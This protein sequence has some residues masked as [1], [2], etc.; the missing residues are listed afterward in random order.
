MSNPD[1][2]TTEHNL[3]QSTHLLNF[4]VVGIGASAGGLEALQELFTELPLT[5]G[6]AF[7]IVQHLSPDYRS[8]MDELLA[9][10]TRM[11]IH[12][13]EDGMSIEEN[14]IY[15][16]PPGK[17]MTIF[18]GKLLLTDQQPTRTLNLPIDIFLRSLAADQEQNAIGI[19][20]SGTGSDGA[21]GIR[22]IKENGGIAMVQDD[23][24]AKFDGMPRSSIST[25]M[26]DFILPPAKIADELVNYVKHPFVKS[27]ADIEQMLTNDDN[28]LLK[29][30]SILRTE[31][32]IDFSDY[33]DSTILRRLEK[34]ISINRLPGLDEYV[35][36]IQDNTKEINILYNEF[37]IGV[38]R[39]FRDD[40]AFAL[41]RK[42]VIPFLI[43]ADN[44][45]KELRVWVVGCSTGE[46]AYSIAITLREYMEEHGL[47][48]DI[49]IF[50]SDIDNQALE[51]AGLGLYP[52]SIAG[53]ISPARI[54]RYFVKKNNGYQVSDS[55]RSMIIF[56][57]HNILQD[58]PFSKI[59][60]ITCRNVLIYFK[61]P[62]QQKVLSLFYL[63]LVENGYLFLGSSESLGTLSDGFH[64]I[65]SKAKLFRQHAGHRHMV[66]QNYGPPS[67]QTRKTELKE[68]GGFVGAV[69]PRMTSIEG[70]FGQILSDYIPPT[71]IVDKNYNVI[72]TINDTRKFISFPQGQITLNILKTL[73]KELSIVA[74]NLLKRAE[75][76]SNEVY[77]DNV[78]MRSLDDTVLTLKAKKIAD[79]RTGETFYILS[80][81]EKNKD[82][83]NIERINV[84]DADIYK[85]YQERVED[86]ERELQY[87][88]ENL[89]ATVEEL[90]TS[91]EELQS[92]NEEL[93][94]S[95]EELQSTNEELQSVNEELYTV[96]SE[97]IRKIDELM[98][99]SSDIENLFKNTSIGTIFL[100]RHLTIRKVNETG[101]FLTNILNS[102]I[103]RPVKHL[104]FQ[105]LYPQFLSDILQVVETLEPIEK[106]I[107]AKNNIWYLTRIIPYRTADNAVNGII[108]LFIDISGLKTSRDT[109]SNLTERLQMAMEVGGI[110]WWEWNRKNDEVYT[111]RGK[112]EMLGWK[113]SDIAPGFAGWMNL[114]HPEDKDRVMQAMR[115][116]LEG[117]ADYYSVVY[118]IQTITG[119]YKWYKDKGGT[120]NRD[121]QGKPSYLT[122]VVMD[123]TIEK[124][125][126][127]EHEAEKLFMQRMLEDRS[128]NY[129]Q[130]FLTIR[131]GV[132]F[133]DDTGKII[134]ANPEAERIL[135]L[136][137]EQMQGLKPIDPS[138]RAIR[139]D[140]SDFPGE[141]H[142]ASVTLRNGEIVRNV[143]MGIF[144]PKIQA[145][146]W[147]RVTAI[148][149][150]E[151]ACRKP[152][153]V[154]ATF[155]EILNS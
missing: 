147:I 83:T 104:S 131:Q 95:N 10:Y 126:E 123:I 103:G 44:Q 152:H 69:R 55:I 58:P 6:V 101:S 125:H 116:H 72:H 117:K 62:S 76:K 24:S 112:Y 73:P 43:K 17:N 53:E 155:E 27:K 154:Y 138:W 23:R 8:L 66:Y 75:K 28:R 145:H 74:G 128:V 11:V 47:F 97:H 94:A 3:Q 96:N 31:K 71:V 110:S 40:D 35:R 136:S 140:G 7:V 78:I 48:K 88:S 92:S 14:H 9:R 49:K 146:T 111:G 100:D 139:E 121:S 133:H 63:S 143:K 91:N 2:N 34:R 144:N 22:A 21:L 45:N 148:P 37:L 46:E 153:R 42:Q 137:F 84:V 29:L 39:F 141:A 59:D 68:Y 1:N 81:T 19:I 54:A 15:L 124:K 60:L 5:P 26:V 122:G 108:I 30:I 130:L 57:K 77:V 134:M 61:Q 87:K 38:T 90:E 102:D 36:F 120:L 98:E 80:F 106:E 4:P 25:G 129:E 115:D 118:R 132:V 107:F 135:G 13:V 113:K 20:L 151:A 109:I 142:P 67:F 50:A 18:H 51:Y 99:L 79:D 93:I 150:F 119:E 41:L 86:L 70:V 12:R 65:D 32:G 56:A 105:S 64:T 33:K 85:Q 52:E 114:V 149:L 82:T 16:I 127:A 89:Q